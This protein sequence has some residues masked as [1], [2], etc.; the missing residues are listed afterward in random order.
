MFR[1]KSLEGTFIGEVAIVLD[2]YVHEQL[3]VTSLQRWSYS[4]TGYKFAFIRKWCIRKW[5]IAAQTVKAPQ[6]N[7]SLSFP[8]ALY[9][10]PASIF[11]FSKYVLLISLDK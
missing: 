9:F 4:K 2:K 11:S 3:F 8:R 6:K 5:C 1:Q 7:I 10:P